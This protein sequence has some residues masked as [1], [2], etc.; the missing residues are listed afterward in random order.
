LPTS[1]GARHAVD[2]GY[3]AKLLAPELAL[4]PAGQ[5]IDKP[6][7]VRRAAAVST[8]RDGPWLAIRGARGTRAD[9]GQPTNRHS[10]SVMVIVRTVERPGAR[11]AHGSWGC[12]G[13]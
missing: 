8:R 12:P 3:L 4:L 1:S 10:V 7:R 13:G 6:L 2:A 5:L 9:A 11:P